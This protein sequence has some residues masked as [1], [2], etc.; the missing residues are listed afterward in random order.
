MQTVVIVNA[1]AW[2]DLSAEHGSYD[3][4]VE[5]LRRTCANVERE[6][7]GVVR[8]L[9]QV[10]VARSVE[11]ALAKLD[12]KGVLVFVTRGMLGEARR[13]KHQHPKIRVVVL[14]SDVLDDEVL[15][16]DK[17][18]SLTVEQLRRVILRV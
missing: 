1:G 14:T 5:H 10:H 7:D 13:I 3:A 17:T 8:E 16:V 2:R 15:I 12:D 6:P 11:E 18:L 9:V 4:F